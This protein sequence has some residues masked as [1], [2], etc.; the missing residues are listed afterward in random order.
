D[1]GVTVHMFDRDLQEEIQQANNAFIEPALERAAAV[2]E[3]KKPVTITLSNLEYPFAHA[4]L[5]DFSTEALERYRAVAGL[6]AAVGSTAFTRRLVL[7]GLLAQ[8]GERFVP[9]GFGLLLFGKEPRVAM[10]QAGLLGTIYYPTGEEVK[11]FDGLQVLAPE[12]ALQWL[13]D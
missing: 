3:E 6:D 5:G 9:T 8:E 11:D 2:K 4:V 12:Q 10:P 1:N 7:Q 13:R